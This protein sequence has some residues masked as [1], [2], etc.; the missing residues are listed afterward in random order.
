M[1]LP[2][3]T[4]FSSPYPTPT[5]HRTESWASCAIQ[6]ASQEASYFTRESE[7]GKSLSRVWLFATPWTCRVQWTS[8]GQNTG[9]G[10]L[11]LLQGI[12][13]IQESNQALPHCRQVP[14][15]LSYPGDPWWYCVYISATVSG[16]PTLSFTRCVHKSVSIPALEI[17]S[18]VLLS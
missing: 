8:P 13:L 15:Q 11:S 14:Y 18:S 9:V 3:W 6:A 4:S 2:S 7:K 1:S 16:H 5:H 12:F 10:S 17:G